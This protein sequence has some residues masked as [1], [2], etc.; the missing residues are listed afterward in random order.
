MQFYGLWRIITKYREKYKN[1][2]TPS[3]SKKPGDTLKLY[4]IE[5]EN[6]SD[7]K[8]M[9]ALLPLQTEIKKVYIIVSMRKKIPGRDRVTAISQSPVSQLCSVNPMKASTGVPFQFT[10]LAV[11]SSSFFWLSL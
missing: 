9:R 3:I 6:T 11:S 8:A 7:A 2:A 1:K 4:G 5:K 10:P